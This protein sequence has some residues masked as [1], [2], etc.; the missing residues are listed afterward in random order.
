MSI[1]GDLTKGFNSQGDPDFNPVRNKYI[2]DKT[3]KDYELN[4][5]RKMKDY[6]KVLR[7]RTDA[8]ACYLTSEHGAGSGKSVERYFGRKLLNKLI[9]EE[10]LER[11]R[12]RKEDTLNLRNKVIKG[13]G[14]K[15]PRSQ[16]WHE[17]YGEKKPKR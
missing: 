8:V 1:N 6:E 4:Q 17:Q 2:I 9:G 14:Y 10:L 15:I 12:L 13:K 5:K 3:I 16:A 11:I 7:E